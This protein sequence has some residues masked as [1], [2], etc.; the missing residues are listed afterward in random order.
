[1]FL[2]ERGTVLL[3]H[4]ANGNQLPISVCGSGATVGLGA[5]ILECP[6]P[7]DVTPRGAAEVVAVAADSVRALTNSREYASLIARSLAAETHVLTKRCAALQSQTVRSRVLTILSELS[8]DA[9]A[10]PINVALP[11]Q[12]LAVMAAADLAHVCRVMR[13]LR[14]EGL[15]DYGKRRLAIRTPIRGFA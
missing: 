12:D 4:E 5:A 14:D 1:V 7:A 6:Y 2:V 15:I 8:G 11:M 3:H 10:Y 9:G 13:G